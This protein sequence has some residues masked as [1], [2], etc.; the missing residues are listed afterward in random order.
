[1]KILNYNEINS[2]GKLFWIGTLA[3]AFGCFTGTFLTF[4]V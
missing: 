3:W 2:A 4:F 1:M